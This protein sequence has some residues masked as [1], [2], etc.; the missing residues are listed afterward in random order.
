MGYCMTQRDSM[1]T[2]KAENTK[3]ALNAIKELAGSETIEDS[4]GRHFSWVDNNYVNAETL[5]DALRAWR[6]IVEPDGNGDINYIYFNGEKLGD[7]EVLFNALAPFID[8]D[9]FI[10]MSGEDGALW[11]WCFENGE[12]KERFANI[13]WE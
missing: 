11:R 2:I 10:E 3:E 13:S 7:D 9:C 4:G 1:F 6:W 5:E 8:D 12:C